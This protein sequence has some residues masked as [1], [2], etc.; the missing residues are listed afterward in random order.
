MNI[1]DADIRYDFDMKIPYWKVCMA[2]E[3]AEKKGKKVNVVPDEANGCRLDGWTYH[4]E[5]R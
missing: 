2:L 5:I 4:L 1:A 3:T